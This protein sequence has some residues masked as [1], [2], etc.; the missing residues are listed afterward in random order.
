MTVRHASPLFTPHMHEPRH[1]ASTTTCTDVETSPA[2]PLRLCTLSPSFAT[3]AMANMSSADICHLGH[4]STHVDFVA[5]VPPLPHNSRQR[6]IGIV[7]D[8]CGKSSVRYLPD[9][10]SALGIGAVA[11]PPRRALF[12]H[13]LLFHPTTG[14]MTAILPWQTYYKHGTSSSSSSSWLARHSPIEQS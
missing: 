6:H 14:Q 2:H 7:L 8:W 3:A 13:V 11:P 5:D 12:V 9:L 10:A 4:H 1:S